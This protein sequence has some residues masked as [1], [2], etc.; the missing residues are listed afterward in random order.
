MQNRVPSP[1]QEGRVLITPENGGSAFYATIEMA[2][3]PTQLGT[4]WSVAAVLQNSTAA[5]FGLG[6][7]AVPDDVFQY[8]AG[9]YVA[10]E[11]SYVGNGEYD[12][13]NPTQITFTAP[14][15]I[16]FITSAAERNVDNSCAI[17]F[18]VSGGTVNTLVGTGFGTSGVG[19]AQ[20]TA[21]LT[22]NTLSY[23]NASSAKSQLNATGITY[24]YRALL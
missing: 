2:D 12:S 15:K 9:A 21:S 19:V 11:G 7:S 10:V 5:L 6:S 16:V 22:G 24:Y 23:Y 17:I 1:G 8:L 13:P 3:N 14:P 20:L 18:P 4:P